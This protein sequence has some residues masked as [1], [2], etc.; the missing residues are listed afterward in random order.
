[1]DISEEEE[2]T[3]DVENKRME[4][5]WIGFTPRTGEKRKSYYNWLSKQAN[6]MEKTLKQDGV[7]HSRTR[8][9]ILKQRKK[10]YEEE[11]KRIKD[12]IEDGR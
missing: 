7:T 6:Q 9:D 1:M 2:R 12:L 5:K 3:Q 4:E 10:A 8:K 11:A